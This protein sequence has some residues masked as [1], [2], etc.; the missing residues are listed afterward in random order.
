MYICIYIYILCIERES[1]S[2]IYIYIYIIMY[3]YT[4]IYI[5]IHT[6]VC[7]YIYI[8]MYTH[9]LYNFLHFYYCYLS[10]LSYQLVRS[11]GWKCAIVGIIY[12]YI[13]TDIICVCMYIYIYIYTCMLK[14]V[15][16]LVGVP[17][18]GSISACFAWGN[19]YV[20]SIFSKSAEK[21]EPSETPRHIYDGK[22]TTA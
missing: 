21:A 3:V 18:R 14:G 22:P 19:L 15:R 6:C 9:I 20:N 11:S 1:D 17:W 13:Y 7:V 8:Y 4:Y 5:Y 10:S 16:F 2:C 12:I